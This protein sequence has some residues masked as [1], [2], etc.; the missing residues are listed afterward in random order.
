MVTI[1]HWGFDGAVRTGRLVVHRDQVPA[2]VGVFHRLFDQRFAIERMEPVEAYGG[3]D[4]ASMAANNTSAFNCRAVTG[5]TSFSQHSYGWAVDVN[6]V[7]NP[8]VRGS[9]VLPPAGRANLDR[10][11]PGTG[12]I[13]A[14]DATVAAFA[15]A[16]WS[17]GGDWTSP[18]DYQHFE[19]AERSLATGAPSVVSWGSGRID[20]ARR[21]GDDSVQHRAW[22]G[23]SWTP[24]SSLGGGVIAD[25]DVASWDDDRLDVFALGQ[26]GALWHRASS[27]G[28]SSWAPWESLGGALSAAPAAVSWGPGRID[29][30]ARAVDGALWSINWNGASWSGW[31]PLDGRITSSPDVSAGTPGRLDVVARGTDGALYH[32]AF[33]GGSWLGWEGL[34]GGLSSGPS[35]V[36]WGPGRL[37]VFARGGDGAL[38]SRAWLGTGW[39]GWYSLGGGLSSGPDAV[40]QAADRIDVFVAGT[41]GGLYRQSWDGARWLGFA[42]VPSG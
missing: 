27:N 8:Y 23:A 30:F 14:G 19:L 17:W 10:S 21:A 42:P 22:T 36:S 13:R 3:S 34:G 41:D 25:P 40:S 11:T 20:Q 26:D 2:I 29:V 18:R 28:G 9:T 12:K 32:R 15:A 39:G 38:W 1:T 4:D 5:G 31:Y 24:W 35:A 33:A 7:Q 16:G 6:P 37:D